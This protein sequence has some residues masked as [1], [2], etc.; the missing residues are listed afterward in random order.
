MRTMLQFRRTHSGRKL[1]AS[2]LSMLLL[3]VAIPAS[4]SFVPPPNQEPPRSSTSAGGRRGC[5]GIGTPM[6][7]LAPQANVGLTTSTRPTFAWFVPETETRR[8]HFFLREYDPVGTGSQ[9][10]YDTRMNSTP[11]VMKFQLPQTAPMLQVGRQYRWKAV[12]I[13]DPDNEANSI[14]IQAELKVLP[15]PASLGQKLSQVRSSSERANLFGASGF[16][17]DSFA[18]ALNIQDRSASSVQVALLNGLLE[19]E[20][21]IAQCASKDVV[22][23]CGLQEVIEGLRLQF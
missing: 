9:E 11:G 21:R 18:E 5:Q 19:A 1:I 4:G 6:L 13:C 17:Y 12:L 14:E 2:C 23:S 10:I 22:F 7:P 16:W 20:P 3:S 15:M 8:I